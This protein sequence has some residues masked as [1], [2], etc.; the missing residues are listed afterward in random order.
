LNRTDNP[1]RWI[2]AYVTCQ[3][4]TVMGLSYGFTTALMP[5]GGAMAGFAVV[6]GLYGLMLPLALLAPREFAPLAQMG[7]SV[8]PGAKGWIALGAVFCQ[9]AAILAVWVYLKPLGQRAGLSDATIG[10]AITL[11]LGSQIFAGLCATAIAG[12]VRAGPLLITVSAVS[13]VIILGLGLSGSSL[14][15]TF[16]A[17]LFAFF[18]MF[19][20]P[21]QMPYLIHM[22]ASRRTAVHMSSALLLG[23][24]VGPALASLAVSQSG[25]GGALWVAGLLYGLTALMILLNRPAPA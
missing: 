3:A 15:F 12:R 23:V 17:V 18:W 6:A 16:G 10:L 1:A 5:W 13:V 2:A 7:G 9:V 11:A 14:I 19:S 22:D 21:F 20:A 24:A 25:L 4:A 8:L